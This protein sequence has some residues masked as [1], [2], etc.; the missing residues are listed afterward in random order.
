MAGRSAAT[1]ATRLASSRASPAQAVDAL[2]D[3]ELVCLL[4]FG[5]DLQLRLD[6][7]MLC[8]G[9]RHLLAR[10]PAPALHRPTCAQ[11]TKQSRSG[12]GADPA[13]GGPLHLFGLRG[14]CLGPI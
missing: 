7:G 12:E 8:L 3:V 10:T 5:D 4:S 13:Q 11:H 9:H 1:S 2:H 6:L 14:L